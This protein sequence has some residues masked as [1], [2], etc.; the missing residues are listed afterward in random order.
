MVI[1]CFVSDLLNFIFVG[2]Y[3]LLLGVFVCT[4]SSN[5]LCFRLCFV[6]WVWFGL[7]VVVVVKWFSTS[8]AF[9]GS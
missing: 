6:V 2:F 7:F 1:E 5:R 8:N 4:T 3:C 9:G